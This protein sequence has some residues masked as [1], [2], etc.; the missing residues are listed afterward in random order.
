MNLNILL[1][2]EVEITLKLVIDELETRVSQ[3]GGIISQ[4]LQAGVHL[5][6][7]PP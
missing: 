2:D 3:Q 4:E 5:V 6:F 1:T 7:Y